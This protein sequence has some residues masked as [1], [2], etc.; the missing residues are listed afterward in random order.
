MKRTFALLLALCMVLSLCAC[1]GTKEE[2]KTQEPAAA[3]AAETAA[4]NDDI[5]I[6]YTND[7]HCGVEDGLTYQGIAAVKAGLEAAGKTVLL[8]DCGDHSQGGTI[9]TLSKG[10]YI[11]DIM[12]E[13]GYALAIPGYH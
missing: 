4:V 5:V 3:P 13:V 7:V 1:G 11:I 6:L 2:A 10:E 9:G 8:V 12:N